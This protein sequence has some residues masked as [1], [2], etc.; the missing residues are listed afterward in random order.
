RVMRD[1]RQEISD[2]QAKLLVLREQ[3]RRAGRPGPDARVLDLQEA[4][5]DADSHT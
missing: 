4:S 1:M 2:M 5:G 3:Q